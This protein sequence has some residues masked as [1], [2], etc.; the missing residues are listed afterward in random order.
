MTF[1]FLSFSDW[2]ADY[3]DS[4]TEALPSA[5]VNTVLGICVV[6]AAL[7]F[8]SFIISLFKYIS[9]IEKKMKAKKEAKEGKKE[10]NPPAQ[11]A[12]DTVAQ[13]EETE[14]LTGDSE[15]VAVIM[16]AIYAYEAEQGTAVNTVN[17]GLVVRSIRKAAKNGWQNA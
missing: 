6:F 7:I 14:A 12:G 11:A 16:A 4:V 8:I 15:L 13:T 5:L 2:W 1:V 3:W 17:N 10:N 9:V